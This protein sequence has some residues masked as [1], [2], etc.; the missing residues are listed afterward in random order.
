MTKCFDFFLK[1][2]EFA[3]FLTTNL[4]ILVNLILSIFLFFEHVFCAKKLDNQWNIKKTSSFQVFQL[5][6]Q[7]IQS[8]QSLCSFPHIFI[9]ISKKEKVPHR[10]TISN[11]LHPPP[12]PIVPYH[13]ICASALSPP[14]TPIVRL[15]VK[16]VSGSKKRYSGAKSCVASS[17]SFMPVNQS[18]KPPVTGL[19]QSTAPEVKSS[20]GYTLLKTDFLVG[21][22]QSRPR[23]PAN[24]SIAQIALITANA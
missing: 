5:N 23:A 13:D 16:A 17:A 2:S 19:P 1:T 6:F 11:C 22:F 12:S 4:I 20:P 24:C 18:L 15:P 3:P 8:H 9:L 7:Q 10:S 21:G 14:T